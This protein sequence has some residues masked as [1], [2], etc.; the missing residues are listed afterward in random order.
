MRHLKICCERTSSYAV[1][2]ESFPLLHAEWRYTRERATVDKLKA[3]ARVPGSLFGL[4]KPTRLLHFPLG[5]LESYYSQRMIY[6]GKYCR[7]VCL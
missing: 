6:A 5:L 1:T 2:S 3:V 4:G 7:L